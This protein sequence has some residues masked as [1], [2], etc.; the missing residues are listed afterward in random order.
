MTKRDPVSIAADSAIA[1]I[2]SRFE[3][4]MRRFDDH[5]PPAH[6]ENRML[7]PAFVDG[8][9]RMTQLRPIR[10]AL[11]KNMRAGRHAFVTTVNGV[12]IAFTP[13]GW[14]TQEDADRQLAKQRKRGR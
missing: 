13:D 4:R 12:P 11:T 2:S 1:A 6:A 9:N 7:S 10:Q 8:V 5:R 14:F 3:R